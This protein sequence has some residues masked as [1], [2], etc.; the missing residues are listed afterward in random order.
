MSGNLIDLRRRIGSVK[1]T[2]KI[3]RA[4]KTVSAAKLRRSLGELNKSRPYLLKTEAMLKRIAGVIDSNDF[5]LLEEREEGQKVVVAVSGEKG[6]CGAFNS[7]IIKGTE[8]EIADGAFIVAVGKKICKYIKKYHEKGYVLYDS[9]MNNLSF[10]SSLLLS[11][12]LKEIWENGIKLDEK[13]EPL[14][15][16]SISFLYTHYIS[17]GSQ[18]VVKK[19]IFPLKTDDKE[20]EENQPVFDAK[21]YIFEPE[22]EDIFRFLLPKYLESIIFNV[23]LESLVS[24]HTARMMAMDL[25]TKNAGEMINNLTL[26]MNKLRQAAITNEILEII[27]ATEAL[28]K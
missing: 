24:E 11:D 16:S 14:V 4:M 1:N 12:Y 5:S 10:Q 7:H 17:A 18:E 23:L 15:V 9:L 6:L 26:T 2:Q 21:E 27:T 8:S 19:E 13:E 28:N 25:A 3:T 22:P 20:S